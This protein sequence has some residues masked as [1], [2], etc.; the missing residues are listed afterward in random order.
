MIKKIKGNNGK[1][2]SNCSHAWLENLYKHHMEIVKYASLLF[3]LINRL[4]HKK[5]ILL[6]CIDV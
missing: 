4:I 3:Y 2:T 5:K 1:E 6:C